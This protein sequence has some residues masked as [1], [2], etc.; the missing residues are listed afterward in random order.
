MKN[1][2]KALHDDINKIIDDE[3]KENPVTYHK[4]L[5]YQRYDRIG[6]EGTRWTPEKRIKDYR[7]D[8]VVKHGDVV[9]DIGCNTGFIIIELAHS[10]SAGIV[11][12]IEPN[13][14]LC[15]VA[16]LVAKY[17]SVSNA[18]FFDCKFDEF[19]THTKY[20]V[21]LTLAAFYTADGRERE[22]S[23]E[24]FGRCFNLLKPGGS[25]IYESVSYDSK[26]KSIHLTKAKEAMHALNTLFKP[27][28]SVIKPSGSP[29]WVREYFIGEK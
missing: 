7:I 18:K 23:Q 16:E 2:L 22:S 3:R 26:V 4:G 11:H 27:V 21:I 14:W 6:L 8:K 17:L 19:D 24:Y 10:Y 1:D 13:P 20:D 25:I 12:G 29:G 9:L 28:E 15:K 5:P